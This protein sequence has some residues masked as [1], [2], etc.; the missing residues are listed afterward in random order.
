MRKKFIMIALLLGVN[1]MFNNNASSS[2]PGVLEG[3]NTYSKFVAKVIAVRKVTLTIANS[4]VSSDPPTKYWA[5]DMKIISLDV[6]EYGSNL[7]QKTPNSKD[8]MAN[9]HFPITA[10][11][12][13]GYTIEG[14]TKS[15]QRMNESWHFQNTFLESYK[16][17]PINP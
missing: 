2:A 1:F 10:V 8:Q 15:R 4:D 14:E 6:L 9:Y 5:V 3:I 7:K 11:I 12:K 13:E 17:I 16:I